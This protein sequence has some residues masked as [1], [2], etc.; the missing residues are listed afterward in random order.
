MLSNS[1]GL[2]YR[3]SRRNEK[4]YDYGD[5]QLTIYEIFDTILADGKELTIFILELTFA[6]S[7]MK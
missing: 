6:A 7:M 1:R 5:N 4:V 3:M 2:K